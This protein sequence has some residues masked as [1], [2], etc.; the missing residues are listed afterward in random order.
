MIE[1]KNMSF[2]Y[3]RQKLFKDLELSLQ[4]GNIY[5][6]LGKNGAGKTTLLKLICGLRL[7][8]AGTCSVLGFDPAQRPAH[9]LEDICFISE[10]LHVPRNPH[11][12][13]S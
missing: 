1:I 2:G 5:G 4:P 10:D 7:P 6:L 13:L 9:L 8:Q 3:K 12:G 11:A